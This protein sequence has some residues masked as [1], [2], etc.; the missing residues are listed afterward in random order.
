MNPGGEPT[1]LFTKA[2]RETV[3]NTLRWL[4]LHSNFDDAINRAM[5]RGLKVVCVSMGFPW[6]PLWTS[7]RRIICI[8][9]GTV[10]T[11]KS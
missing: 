3:T 1:G 5:I 4:R 6:A 11:A 8:A 7:R 2:N 9:V 10:E